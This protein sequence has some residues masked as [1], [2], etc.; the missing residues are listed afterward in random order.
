MTEKTA[1]QK[2]ASRRKS[3]GEL[4]ELLGIKALV[5]RQFDKIKNTNDTR[6]NYPFADL[7]AEKGNKKYVISVKTRNKYQKD[8]LLNAHYKLGKNARKHAED[9]KNGAEAYWMAVQFDEHTYAIY[10]GSL[11]ELG[12]KNSIP[13]KKCEKGEVGE[14]LVPPTQRHYFSYDLFGNIKDDLS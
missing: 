8:N 6:M 14:C 2:E 9:V 4:G 5:D 1:E 11:D 12:G 13:L 7:Y 3:L 10:F